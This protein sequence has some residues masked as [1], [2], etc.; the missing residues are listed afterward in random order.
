MITTDR[1]GFV[2]HHHIIQAPCFST[3]QLKA[4][5]FSLYHV[6]IQ[7]MTGQHE[8][9]RYHKGKSLVKA[10][11]IKVRN[12]FIRHARS[13]GDFPFE[14]LLSYSGEDDNNY[15]VL[16]RGAITEW[17]DA[18]NPIS[19]AGCSLD[20]TDFTTPKNIFEQNEQYK[21]TID[22]I[23]AGIWDWDIATG[24]EW[25]SDNFFMLLGYGINEIEP[26]YDTFLNL[27]L[28]P[29]DRK[30][31]LQAVSD[32]LENKSPYLL[33]V[34][35]LHK[36]GNYYWFETSGKARF[37]ANGKAVRM[38][39]SVINRHN[40]KVL[41]TDLKKYTRLVDEMSSLTKTGAWEFY[42]DGEQPLWTQQTFDIHEVEYDRQPNL[43]EAINFYYGESKDFITKA[44][45]ALIKAG[46]PYDDEVEM[47]TA[48]G[49]RIWVRTIGRP[50][51]NNEG[52]ITGASGTLQDITARKQKEIELKQSNLIIAAQNKRL[53]NF[54]HIVTHN[55]RSHAGN[56]QWAL[57]LIAGSE[58]EKEEMLDCIDKISSS[59]NLTIADLTQIVKAECNEEL[60]SENV[61]FKNVLSNVANALAPLINETKTIIEAEFDECPVIN[62]APAYLE[63]IIF[64]LV[65]NTIKY[66]HPERSPHIM[67]HTYIRDDKKYLSIADNGIGIDLGKYG[68]KIFGMYKTFHRHPDARGIGLYLTKNMIEKS[69]GEI[70]VYSKP[71]EGSCFVIRF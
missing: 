31:M 24:K 25:W 1:T 7:M 64:N 49:K 10:D 67:I 52:K 57:S 9:A 63:S 54:A 43:A 28:H 22:S 56:L 18:G 26:A 19:M 11:I 58:N 48:K 6:L 4:G 23:N 13:K 66:K 38:T 70:L 60:A 40:K 20:I 12:T 71:A 69:G 35:L 27:L 29:D 62:Y 2:T 16:S 45:T 21:L 32:H 47:I 17:D 5:K 46:T 61:R 8:F 15:S 51:I 30:K 34:R 41:E 53:H 33:E 14:V 3:W 68:D 36:D 42:C 65:S 59:L 50:I 39:G 37:N 55:L 44:F